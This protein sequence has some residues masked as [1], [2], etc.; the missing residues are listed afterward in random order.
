VLRA[1]TRAVGR[2]SP[3][4]LPSPLLLFLLLV[5]S[6]WGSLCNL[7]A[8]EERKENSP[9][10]PCTKASDR[11]KK[12]RASQMEDLGLLQEEGGRKDC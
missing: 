1:G 11:K 5:Y 10:K 6:C 4:P 3:P 8:W 7:G 9:L 12:H 2:S